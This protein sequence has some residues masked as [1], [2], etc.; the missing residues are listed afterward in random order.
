M[1]RVSSTAPVPNGNS[2][3]DESWFERQEV[4]VDET[5]ASSTLNDRLVTIERALKDAIPD[6]REL[7]VELGEIIRAAVDYV[8]DAPTMRRYSLYDLE[9]DEKT[10][11][12]KRIE[13]LIRS[14]FNLSKGQK[15]DV[16][17]AEE[18]VD[19]KTSCTISRSWMFSPSNIDH[20]NLLVAYD[21]KTAVFDL[22]LVL[23]TDD[24]LNAK[25]R[26]IKRQL[27]G[28]RTKRESLTGEVVHV[29]GDIRW[30]LKNESY[31]E[32]FLARQESAVLDKIVAGRSGA[33]RVRNLLSMVVETPIPRQAIAAVA[34]QADPKRRERGG[35]GAR[36][37]L[38]KDVGLLILSGRF[39]A[40][41]D[42]VFEVLGIRLRHDQSISIPASHR[43]LSRA[44]LEK[45]ANEHRLDIAKLP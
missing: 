39:H 32:N 34:N 1:A 28:D 24:V 44:A 4:A 2:V 21:E 41:A 23:I 38:W 40:D 18:D 6:Q 7:A 10:T 5:S 37:K 13:R 17:L 27:K 20:V 8:I 36:G 15:L 45:F 14:R 11:I 22:G 31:P 26:D 29:G 42:L 43:K 35:D 9:P 3:S 19:I 16:R 25:N 12:G 30:I 33:A